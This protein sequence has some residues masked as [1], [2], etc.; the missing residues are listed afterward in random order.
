M[1]VNYLSK[2]TKVVADLVGL[3]I[4]VLL[5]V[6]CFSVVFEGL[7]TSLV[8]PIIE[9]NEAETEISRMIKST[10]ATVGITYRMA[11]LLIVLVVMFVARNLFFIFQASFISWIT[12]RLLVRLRYEVCRD[13]LHSDYLYLLR[14]NTGYL[15]NIVVRE[16]SG[17]LFV[18]REYAN[19]LVSVVFAIMYIAIPFWLNPIVSA[20]VGAVAVPTY[21]VVRRLNLGIRAYSAERTAHAGDL[22]SLLGQTFG[23]FKYLKATQSQDILLNRVRDKSD[24]LGRSQYRGTVLGAIAQN[25]FE[26]LGIIVL[27]LLL[28]YEVEV[29]GKQILEVGFVIYLLRRA[30]AS[31]LGTQQ[32]YA[33]LCG[34][35]GSI[36]AYLKI[37]S[38]L[39][40]VHVRE[41]DDTLAAPDLTQP[42]QFDDV[43]FEYTEGRPVLQGVSFSVAPLK[44]T[45]FVGAS[46]VG[47]ST[48]ADMITGVLKPR[49]G[50]IRVGNH[51]YAEADLATLR[52]RVGYIT[53]ED[54]IFN[55]TIKNNITLW[56]DSKTPHMEGAA[57]LA[58]IHPFIEGAPQ[59]YSSLLGERGVMVSGGQRQR[60]MIARE[61]CKQAAILIFDEATSALD[62][63]TE[64]QIRKNIESLQGEKT[65]VVIAHRLSTVRKADKIYVLRDGRV[66]ED[67][68]Y[69]E[70]RALGG[71]FARLLKQQGMESGQ[72]QDHVQ[73]H[74][75]NNLSRDRR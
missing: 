46:G 6:I 63:D 17:V 8:L 2:V 42:I 26:P 9:G 33:K 15:T 40:D 55:D 7:G 51:D 22:Q 59:G 24:A 16:L 75:A 58:R 62:S 13:I 43:H 32:H 35:A 71:E 18:V 30:I 67:G 64:D 74:E 60:L 14:Q 21:A 29:A 10:F 57:K 61:L 54:V 5:T 34:A 44:T 27:S 50:R 37:Q 68:S 45:A 56:D 53:Q 28:Y 41:V 73:Y 31:L 69:D 48:I 47:K 3:K 38:E 20:G 4:L 1:G 25:A 66:V 70:L 12:T 39:R 11:N 23:F 19:M 49:A 52:S 72:G 65:I 36:D